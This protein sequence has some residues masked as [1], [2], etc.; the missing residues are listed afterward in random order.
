MANDSPRIL[1]LVPT[2]N[3]PSLAE[4]AIRSLVQQPGS[5]VSHWVLVSDNST[6]PADVRKLQRFCA[7]FPQNIVRYI[8][9]A[10]P[11]PMPDHF[12]WAMHQG[13]GF[14]EFTHFA[15][16]TDRMIFR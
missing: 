14:T 8:R 5:N 1:F 3:R 16:L 4:N 7:Q 6:V 2:R 11:L 10:E 15:C 13:L 12:N 9:P